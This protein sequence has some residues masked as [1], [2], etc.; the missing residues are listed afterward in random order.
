MAQLIENLDSKVGESTLVRKLKRL[1][2]KVWVRIG[3]IALLS[4]LALAMTKLVSPLV[5]WK[6]EQMIEKEA[7][8]GLLRII[9]NS[10]LAVTTFSLTVVVSV[11][12]SASSQWSP[13]VHRI[14]MDDTV[15]KN[16]LASLVGA[17]IYSI[18]SIILL[19]LGAFDGNGVAILFGF[20][21]LIFVLIVVAIVRWIVHLQY[22]GSLIEATRRVEEATAKAFRL[23][24]EKPCLGGQALRDTD[25]VPEN[26]VAIDANETGFLQF[27][28]EDAISE[29][30][31][32]ADA[33]V[34]LTSDIGKFV[35][36]GTPVAWVTSDD[37]EF[38]KTVADNISI[39][40]LRTFEQDP[41]FG[42]VVLGEI[43][44]KALSPGI[45]DPGTAIDVLGRMSRIF[46]TYP[47]ERDRPK[48][49]LE[50]PR[51]HVRPLKPSD[52][53]EDGFDPVARDGAGLIEVQLAV[54]N[55]L[56]RLAEHPDDGLSKAAKEA[57]KRA[58]GQACDTLKLDHEKDRLSRVTPADVRND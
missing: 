56:A 20:T 24:M 27:I 2:K 37:E 25:E 15:I 14:L 10:M 16:V 45:N 18:L 55:A 47:E 19:D 42:L 13:R 22:M 5:P 34:Y 28:Y 41:R 8:D 51:L 23:R 39:G 3:L 57:A 53:I 43:G 21:L 44:S 58:W 12:R 54:Q 36:R 4:V 52:L 35:Y 7:V 49:D 32:K 9:A 29:A 1:G 40:D 48:E 30:A 31:E 6:L 11:F 46:E 26:A 38:R 33:E 50:H 17:Y